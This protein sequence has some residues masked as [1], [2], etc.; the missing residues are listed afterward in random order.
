MRL[1]RFVGEQYALQLIALALYRNDTI[2][3]VTILARRYGTASHGG[4]PC[5]P[6]CVSDPADHNWRHIFLITGQTHAI[7]CFG[8]LSFF[9]C[10]WGQP[11]D[12]PV[13][14]HIIFEWKLGLL[15]DLGASPSCHTHHVC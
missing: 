14:C 1:W 9:P 13:C 5:G 8:Q 12:S 11:Q 10:R 4:D 3:L 15:S 7:H 2:A 6:G